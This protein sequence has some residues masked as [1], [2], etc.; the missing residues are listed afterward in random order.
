MKFLFD[1]RWTTSIARQTV[2]HFLQILRIQLGNC[3]CPANDLRRQN[4]MLRN[5]SRKC[6]NMWTTVIWM[7]LEL[8]GANSVSRMPLYGTTEASRL[9]FNVSS[10]IVGIKHDRFNVFG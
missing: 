3:S 6:D 9:V 1:D 5:P 2:P 4:A 10:T 8:V 7:S